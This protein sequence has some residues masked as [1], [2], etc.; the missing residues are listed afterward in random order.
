MTKFLA[1][2]VLLVTT[3]VFGIAA[4]PCII[5]LPED[6]KG[7][8]PVILTKPPHAQVDYALFKPTGKV[9][10]FVEGSTLQLVCTG[11]NNIIK[12]L[13]VT[14][15]QLQCSKSGQ[16]VDANNNVI[17]LST[18]VCNFIPES[19][20]QTTSRKCSH[21]KGFIYESGITVDKMFY[22][23][24]E[25]CYDK[26]S[27]TTLYTH[28]TLNGATLKY[29]ISE[30]TRRNFLATGMKQSTRK[31]NEIYTKKNQFARFEKYFGSDQTF[32]DDKRHFLSRGH[33]T[34]DADFIFGYEQLATYYYTNVALQFQS[35]NGGNWLRVED[36]GRSLAADYGEDFESY[37]GYFGMVQLPKANGAKV[38][39][40]LDSQ[41][42][43]H[44]PKYYFKVL[45]R[46]SA[47]ESIVF[48]NV[49]NPHITNGKAEEVCPNVCD[50]ARLNHKD[51]NNLAKGFTFCCTLEEFKKVYPNLPD[52][53]VGKKILTAIK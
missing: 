15:L 45:L 9:N 31:I 22:P 51:F 46:K 20:L 41:N 29:K 11:K 23:I 24:F 17:A 1:L 3:G 39:I 47:D 5:T 53:V 50:K 6:I 12:S 37:N 48:V 21:N 28:N 7:F 52:E 43:F 8:A 16:F 26:N 4:N 35:I 27:E 10:S 33:L 32:I 25:I 18:L 40:Y 38:K 44:I 36:M 30:S 14:H 42:E 13:K 19:T 34:P 49:N 2:I